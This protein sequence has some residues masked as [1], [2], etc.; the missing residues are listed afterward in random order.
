M[1][2]RMKSFI[3]RYILGYDTAKRDL[4]C[5]GREYAYL[6]YHDNNKI[7]ESFFK[8]Y[9]DLLESKEKRYDHKDLI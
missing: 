4:E 9:Y 3:K 7:D 5:H 2:K 1:T 6:Y 8:G